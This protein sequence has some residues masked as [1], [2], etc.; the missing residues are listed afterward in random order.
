MGLVGRDHIGSHLENV[1]PGDK[2]AS[3]LTSIAKTGFAMSEIIG[4]SVPDSSDDD[5]SNV[6]I[7]STL[8]SSRSNCAVPPQ[9][10][11]SDRSVVEVRDGY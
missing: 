8:V 3:A 7:W 2:A 1:R 4:D 11:R 9:H 10:S 5:R 6:T